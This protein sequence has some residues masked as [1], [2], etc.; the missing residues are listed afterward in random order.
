MRRRVFFVFIIL[1]LTGIALSASPSVGVIEDAPW[2]PGDASRDGAA[3]MDVLLQL[4][5]LRQQQPIVGLVGL[6]DRHG[7][8]QEGT[9]RGFE[10]AARQGVPVVRLARD[11]TIGPIL[12]N[13]LF[14][15]GG[16]LPPATAAILLSECLGRYGSLPKMLTSARPTDA[17]LR[18]FHEKLKLYRAEFAARQPATL[19]LR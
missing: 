12:E 10:Y 7:F 8:F 3:E 18:A 4:A 1:A 2:S 9:R 19:A 13:D 6:G 11:A 5:R 17:E 16:N 14:I 15:A